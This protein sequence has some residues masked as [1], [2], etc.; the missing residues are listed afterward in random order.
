MVK[1]KSVYYRNLLIDDL[2]VSRAAAWGKQAHK[3]VESKV[4]E[5]IKQNI[6]LESDGPVLSEE[7]YY[8]VQ[9][10]T[11]IRVWRSKEDA[12]EFME[13]IKEFEPYFSVSFV[14]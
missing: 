5:L 7:Y 14:E 8:N 10:P 11:V 12:L 3:I 13:F 6:I 2:G 4:N 1:T 9:E